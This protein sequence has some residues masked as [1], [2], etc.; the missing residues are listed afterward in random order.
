MPIKTAVVAIGGN[1]LIRDNT[2]RE[3]KYQWDAVRET[4]G[5]IACMIKEGWRVVIT[6]GN[7]PQ[8]GFILRRAELAAHEVHTMSLDIIGADTQG[9]IGYMIQ[10]A[11]RNSLRVMG[12]SINVISLVT[13]TLVDKN[14]PAFAHPTKPIGGFL[15]EPEARKFEVDGWPIVEDAGRGWRRVVA[16]PQPLEIVELDAIKLALQHDYVVVAAGGGG[17][18]V[19]RNH[20]GELRGA[21]AVI[22]KDWASSLLALGI[23]ADLFVISTGVE[24]VALNFN[25]PDQRWL[26]RVTLAEA[27]QYIQEG[28]FAPGSMLPKVEAVV[29]FLERGGPQ[30][31]ITDPQNIARALRGETGT[32]FVPA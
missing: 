5:H 29:R 2:K 3:M 23:N 7:G 12:L 21:Y 10:Q 22:D 13:Q 8:V 14:D 6:H 27:R 4:C 17:I 20:K 9:S 19:I 30:A 26:D 16:S 28:Q 24:K 15:T 1:S 25:K 32:S 31:L 18:P 11:L